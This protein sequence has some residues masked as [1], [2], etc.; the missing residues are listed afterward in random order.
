[1]NINNKTRNKRFFFD[2]NYKK[3]SKL[4]ETVCKTVYLQHFV[5]KVLCENS[6]LDF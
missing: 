3:D 5:Y 1:M 6:A 4:C 2:C